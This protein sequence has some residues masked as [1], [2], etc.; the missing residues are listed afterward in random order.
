M[1]SNFGHLHSSEPFGCRSDRYTAHCVG[2]QA[3]I[4]IGVKRH[5]R[6]ARLA[7]SNFRQATIVPFDTLDEASEALIA[8]K[9]NAIVHDDAWV[10]AWFQQTDSQVSGRFRALLKPVTREPIAIAL[11]KG[12]PEF[13]RFLDVYVEE[14][15]NDGTVQRLYRKHFVGAAWKADAVEEGSR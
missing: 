10:R 14:V 11:R 1:C 2:G 12:D 8:G 5:T 6:P 4:R 7:A 15:A 13:L 9:L 3:W